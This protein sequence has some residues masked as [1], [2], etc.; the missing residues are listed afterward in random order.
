M[1]KVAGQECVFFPFC[2]KMMRVVYIYNGEGT[3]SESV[4]GWMLVLK[5]ILGYPHSLIHT[6]KA[7]NIVAALK[8]QEPFRTALIVP[9]GADLA[10]VKHLTNNCVATIHSVI[11]AGGCYLGI[12]AGAYFASSDCIFEKADLALRVVGS[13]SLS[14]FPHPAVGAVREKFCYGSESGATIENLHCEWRGLPF[15]ADIYCNGGPGWDV[16]SDSETMVIAR[17]SEA[18]LERHGIMTK[19]PVAALSHRFGAKGVVVLCGVHPELPCHSDGVKSS[20]AS[21]N[22]GKL[23][24]LQALLE[25]A[26]LQ[27]EE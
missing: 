19:R 15:E 14:L 16:E 25:A 24:F 2:E 27:S 6:V 7:Y 1:R 26:K 17:Y 21:I 4:I 22:V 13:R 11:S 12:C 23:R 5:N 9:G 20:A 10:Y 8:A 3:S 18:L